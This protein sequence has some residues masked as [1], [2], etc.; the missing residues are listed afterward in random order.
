MALDSLRTGFVDEGPELGG[1]A[2]DELGAE[3]DGS[4]TFDFPREDSSADVWFGFE[5]ADAQAAFGKRS[6][7]YE[8]GHAGT[9]DEHID[10]VR[11]V[12]FHLFLMF[13]DAAR[14]DVVQNFGM[15]QCSDAGVVC[16]W[17]ARNA[18]EFCG[19]LWRCV[20]PEYGDA[21]AAAQSAPSVEIMLIWGE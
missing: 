8:A 19:R 18:I 7:G 15:S 10:I 5:D 12:E 20:R 17:R 16:G 9:E 4:A 3:L 11:Q 14:A 2:V 13:S 6:R 1:A 21:P